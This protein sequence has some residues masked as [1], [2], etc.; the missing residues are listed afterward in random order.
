MAETHAASAPTLEDVV[1]LLREWRAEN[2]AVVARIASLEREMRGLDLR[3]NVL[4]KIISGLL[5]AGAG[6]EGAHAGA[7]TG[8]GEGPA[9]PSS[10]NRPQNQRNSAGQATPDRGGTWQRSSSDATEE[11][12]EGSLAAHITASFE[13]DGAV[14]SASA[15][16]LEQ[17]GALLQ[18][19][20]YDNKT[21]FKRPFEE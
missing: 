10:T 9:S 15:T 18:D 14:A 2:A 16:D 20:V 1:R 17:E 6:D 8:A 7:V 21:A 13:A 19:S 5:A 12:S 11:D 4:N 3:F